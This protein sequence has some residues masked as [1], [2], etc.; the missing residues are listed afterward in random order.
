M[1]GKARLDSLQSALNQ[2]KK[3]EEKSAGDSED[4][5]SDEADS[6]ED[7]DSDAD[8]DEDSDDSPKKSKKGKRDSL[9]ENFIILSDQFLS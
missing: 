3:T 5:D 7:E 2:I 8:S 6:E 1:L 4:E 9:F